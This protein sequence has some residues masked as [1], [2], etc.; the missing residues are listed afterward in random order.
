MGRSRDLFLGKHC[1]FGEFGFL[2]CFKSHAFRNQFLFTFKETNHMKHVYLLSIFALL[3]IQAFAQD[4]VSNKR[5]YIGVTVA[6]SFPVGDFASNNVTGND[7]AGYAKTGF[8][9]SLDFG[10]KL[11]KRWG[12]SACWKNGINSVDEAAFEKTFKDYFGGNWNVSTDPYKFGAILVGPMVTFPQP[13]VDVDIRLLF[14][15]GYAELPSIDVTYNGQFFLA[16]PSENADGFAVLF[17]GSV[18]YHISS[19]VSLLG[20]LNYLSMLAT[21]NNDEIEQPIDVINIDIGVGL[22]L[23]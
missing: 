4:L 19:N 13:K 20:Q 8:S 9:Y 16:I 23:K 6:P 7:K 12:I 21:S 1:Y 22:R 18:R 11:G 5:G 14:G 3:T 2:K 15:Y 10:Y 17:G